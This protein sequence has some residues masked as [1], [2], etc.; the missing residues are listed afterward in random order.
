MPS[1]NNF[2]KLPLIYTMPMTPIL[3]R[4]TT[5]PESSLNPIEQFTNAAAL[6]VLKKLKESKFTKCNSMQKFC[7]PK[8]GYFTA[9]TLQLGC[10]GGLLY[11]VISPAKIFEY[12]NTSSVIKITDDVLNPFEQSQYIVQYTP[13]QLIGFSAAAGIVSLMVF[14]LGNTILQNAKEFH[15]YIAQPYQSK[16]NA[17]CVQEGIFKS[18][19]ISELL[20][21]VYRKANLELLESY[22]AALDHPDE[23]FKLKEKVKLL[24]GVRNNLIG[25]FSRNGF[26]I[27]EC[28]TLLHELQ[29]GIDTIKDHSLSVR[30]GDPFYNLKL[31]KM[32]NE[33]FKS[34][35][36]I[37]Q[38]I[39]ET[40]VL[41][42]GQKHQIKSICL[43]VL[44]GTAL[45][46][47][48]AWITSLMSINFNGGAT[49]KWYFWQEEKPIVSLNLSRAN[50]AVPSIVGMVPLAMKYIWD[51]KR[52]E[53]NMH[54]S[55]AEA[56]NNIACNRLKNIYDR[57]ADYLE[58]HCDEF[59]KKDLA[60]ILEKL[61]YVENQIGE[62]GLKKP[63]E[64]TKKLR[65]YL[66]SKLS[67]QVVAS[68]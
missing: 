4:L 35:V 7:F 29:V 16:E 63:E 14:S 41:P 64:N 44:G 59:H 34:I 5:P 25:I 24:D 20:K 65:L 22:K 31:F 15:N 32:S 11:K 6:T 36:L 28:N 30:E 68:N 57:M 17:I 66:E 2:T 67:S 8:L 13:Y 39:R 48:T 27:E 23:M 9:I 33:A 53:R 37:P 62:F 60:N 21:N 61:I 51:K 47:A 58:K 52:I 26:S 54:N 46:I 50:F 18:V 1:C 40:M 42:L 38:S 49:S 56:K 45:T 12:F 10:L 55:K 43:S 3:D 19:I